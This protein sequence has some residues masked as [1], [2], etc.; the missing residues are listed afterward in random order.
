[1]TKRRIE[2][3]MRVRRG[4]KP[5]YAVIGLM[6]AIATVWMSYEFWRLIW[7]PAAASGAVDLL[8]RYDETTSFVAGVPVYWELSDA[9]YPPASYL[10]MWPLIGWLPEVLVRPVWA[11]QIALLL[12]VLAYQLLRIVRPTQTAGKAFLIL[13]PLCLY[14]TG[15]AI[16]NGQIVLHLLPCLIGCLLLLSRKPAQHERLDWKETVAMAWLMLLAL[17]KPNVTAPFFW[18][19]LFR[20]PLSALITAGLYAGMTLFSTVFQPEFDG[21]IHLFKSWLTMGMAG[22]Y[23]GAT[24]YVEYEGGGSIESSVTAHSVIGFFN[25]DRLDF[26]EFSGW[27]QL[28]SLTALVILGIWTY[29]NRHRDVWL[30]AGVAAVVSKYWTY[31]G[32]YDDVVLIIPMVALLK[33]LATAPQTG[34]EDTQAFWMK[35]VPR[36]RGRYESQ[37]SAKH[38]SFTAGLFVAM[39]LCLLA[40]GGTYLLPPPWRYVYLGFQTLVLFVVMLFLANRPSPQLSTR[41]SL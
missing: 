38:L 3:A 9:V 41:R 13:L 26:V 39:F 12:G 32:W 1:M 15:A 17:V 37:Q 7:Q 4:V 5:I 40:P 34:L 27:N 11:A 21:P 28:V 35:Y 10:M 36:L 14:A 23:Y 31:H 33:L 16:G 30:L 2:S 20:A 29:R 19:L 18:I 25:F 22:V 8:Y 6:A 24:P